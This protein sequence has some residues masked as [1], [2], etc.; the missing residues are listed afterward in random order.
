MFNFF[1]LHLNAGWT[2]PA[3]QASA[4]PEHSSIPTAGPAGCLGIASRMCWAIYI[5]QLEGK[6]T[7]S[8]AMPSMVKYKRTWTSFGRGLRLDNSNDRRLFAMKNSVF[9]FAKW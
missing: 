3:L 7:I 1:K 4:L 2:G 8:I 5:S 6:V 9:W